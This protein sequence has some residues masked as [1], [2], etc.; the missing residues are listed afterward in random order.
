MQEIA[1]AI[2]FGQLN[3]RDLRLQ[4]Q[5]GFPAGSRAPRTPEIPLVPWVK[6]PR[7]VALAKK[8]RQKANA[9]QLRLN[10]I[11]IWSL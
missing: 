5:V 7:P 4:A 6:F 2:S 9:V 1:S 8:N 3:R 10:G 11:F